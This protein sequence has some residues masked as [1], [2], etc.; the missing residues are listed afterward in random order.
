MTSL[1]P[2]RPSIS[3]PQQRCELLRLRFSGEEERAFRLDYEAGSVSSRVAMLIIG[4]V[5]IGSTPLY[6]VALLQA[7]P[8][9]VAYTRTLQFGVQIPVLLLGLLVN[10]A[11]SLRPLAAPVMIAGMLIFGGSLCAEYVAGVRHG[12]SVPHDVAT[13]AISATCLLGRL[14]FYLLLPWA[15]ALML[16]V[17]ATQLRVHESSSAAIYDVIGMWMQFAVAL[18]AA[19]LL[20]GSARENWVQ[21][22]L[23]QNEAAQDALTQLPN[24][25]HF[26]DALVRLVREAAR[27]RKGVALMMVDVDLFKAYNDRYG[28]PAGDECLRRI[29]RW[30]QDSMR[31]PQ[32]F[33]ARIGG[34][35]FVAVWFDARPETATVM[36]EALRAG[37]RQLAIERDDA[38]DRGVVS[39]SGGFVQVLPPWPQ[40]DAA[41]IASEMVASADRL[42]YE[43][44]RLGR[45][46][47]IT[48]TGVMVG[49][50]SLND[51]STGEN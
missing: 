24:R 39:A 41:S 9:F 21:R 19:Y 8:D 45:D 28:H 38:G 35:E 51:R 46:R 43:A 36:A 22:R 11:P 50:S 27:D 44:K 17:T 37:V 1:P 15:F 25:R 48:Q 34:E 12:F 47:L 3:S 14:R 33:C 26:D 23:L 2:S 40:D 29:A 5:M 49:A 32:D 18:T 10:L 30:M 42:L 13:L 4:I 6:D 7:P 31:R 16:G 20:E